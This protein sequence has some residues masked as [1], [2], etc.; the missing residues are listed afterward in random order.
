[1]MDIEAIYNKFSSTHMNCKV[2]CMRVP[3]NI[4]VFPFG[5]ENTHIVVL[6][7]CIK[8]D[9]PVSFRTIRVP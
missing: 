1:M 3:V 2:C 4:L 8:C 6:R 9:S 5:C 7:S